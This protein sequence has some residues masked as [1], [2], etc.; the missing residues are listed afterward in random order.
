M[1]SSEPSITNLFEV[2]PFYIQPLDHLPSVSRAPSKPPFF[3]LSREKY[4]AYPSLDFDIPTIKNK[5]FLPVHTLRRTSNSAE[6]VSLVPGADR[7]EP[8]NE[9]V[10]YLLDEI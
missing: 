7:Y 10:D 4:H 5:A 1:I 2:V 8:F 9:Y 3:R 6:P